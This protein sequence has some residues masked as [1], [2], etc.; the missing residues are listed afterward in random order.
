M[1][2]MEPIGIDEALEAL[3]FFAS[4]PEATSEAAVGPTATDTTPKDMPPQQR[5]VALTKI[6]AKR[7]LSRAAGTNVNWDEDVIAYHGS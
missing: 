4:S 7:C 2:H 3:G 1:V 5:Q 6:G